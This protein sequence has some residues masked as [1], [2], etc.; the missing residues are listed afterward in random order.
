MGV[1]G[2]VRAAGREKVRSTEKE[3]HFLTKYLG[4]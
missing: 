4:I 3:S 1:P 2:G